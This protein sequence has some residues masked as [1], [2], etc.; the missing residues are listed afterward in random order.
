MTVDEA[1]VS[2]VTPDVQ[3]DSIFALLAQNFQMNA[4]MQDLPVAVKTFTW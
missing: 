4:E 2:P 3:P 1:D